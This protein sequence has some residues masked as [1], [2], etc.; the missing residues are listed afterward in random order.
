MVVS[1]INYNGG[2]CPPNSD[3]YNCENI[4]QFTEM[5][6]FGFL[7]GI[8]EPDYGPVLVSAIDV[9]DEACD[10]YISPG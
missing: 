10:N 1:F 3:Y 9:I 2:A 7:A 8:C 5:F 4:K 6:T